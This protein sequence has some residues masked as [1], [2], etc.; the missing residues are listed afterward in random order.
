MKTM[1]MVGGGKGGVGKSTVAMGLLD[2]LRQDGQEPVYVETDDS[3]P[4]VYKA[5]ND[6]VPCE[7][8]TLDT[9]SGYVRLGDLMESNTDSPI[10]VNTPARAIPGILEHGGILCDVAKQTERRMVMVWPLNRQRDGLELLKQ[11]VD[12][13]QPYAATYALLNTY[14]G[15]VDKFARYQASKLKDRVTGTVIFPELN[16]LVADR[17][18]DQRLPLWADDGKF[19]LAQRSV[20]TRYRAAARDA[21]RMVYEG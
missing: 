16:D 19:T 3:N 15:T 13:G 12:A 8:C 10:V 6:T 17:L 18:I 20:L 21:L 9:E 4:D 5:V 2:A 1:I 11:F 7:I 14:F